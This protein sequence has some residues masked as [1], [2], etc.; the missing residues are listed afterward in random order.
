MLASIQAVFPHLVIFMSPPNDLMV[1]ASAEPISI[2][3]E[4]LERRFN[5]LQV[6]EDFRRIGILTPGQLMFYFLSAGEAIQSYT[7]P[8]EALNTDD[9]VWLE[10]RMPQEFFSEQPRLDQS[11]WRSFGDEKLAALEQTI[12]GVD[13]GRVLGEIIGYSYA[14]DFTLSGDRII[15]PILGWRTP[16]LDGIA[17]ELR[18]RGDADLMATFESVQRERRQQYDRSLQAM[19]QASRAVLDPAFRQDQR[20]ARRAFEEAIANDPDLPLVLAIL[21]SQALES[22]Q[23]P[24]A[25]S[26]FRRL[27]DRP[28]TSAHYDA[29]IG[30]SNAALR[31]GDNQRAFEFLE[32]AIRHNPYH[33]IGFELAARIVLERGDTEGALEIAGQGLVF[34]PD[35]E[36][37]A[38][39][40]DK[41][42]QSATGAR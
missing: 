4:E 39:I 30:L 29:L 27:L 32:L 3:W 24:L 2:P 41:V 17:G 7:S 18:R 10:H 16:V 6:R 22:Q 11:L 33:A 34:N 28:W 1:L 14:P 15:D 37:L 12:P 38:A 35:A 5:I 21:G 23:Y 42:L 25:E 20:L 19:T 26:F 40:R 36:G 13:T 31:S 8:A 9:N